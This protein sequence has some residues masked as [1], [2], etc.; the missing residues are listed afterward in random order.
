MII[1]LTPKDRRS[2][3][4]VIPA[5]PAPLIIILQSL[6]SFSTTFAALI[7][8]ARVTIAVPC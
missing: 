1:S 6:R 5:A 8:P 3:A 4:I 7:N 2:F